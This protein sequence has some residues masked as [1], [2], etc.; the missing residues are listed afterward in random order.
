[1]DVAISVKDLA[2]W[3]WKVTLATDRCRSITPYTT[4]SVYPVETITASA[5]LTVLLITA[6]SAKDFTDL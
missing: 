1:M 4:V 3:M 5:L 2:V 6:K